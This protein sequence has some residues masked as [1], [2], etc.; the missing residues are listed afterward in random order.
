MFVVEA[1]LIHG[2][3]YPT[4]L[5]RGDSAGKSS[6]DLARAREVARLQWDPSRDADAVI[7]EFMDGYYGLA[8]AQLRQVLRLYHEKKGN[9]VQENVWG[10]AWLPRNGWISTP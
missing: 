5:K 3:Q 8:A 2:A 4:A 7:Q 6:D 10:K 1:Q 9:T